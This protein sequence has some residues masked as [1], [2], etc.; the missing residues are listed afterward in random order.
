MAS[1]PA[2]E[3]RGTADDFWIAGPR[4]E[5]DVRR[6]RLSTARRRGGCGCSCRHQSGSVDRPLVP[7]ERH[8]RGAARQ[9]GI[10]VLQTGFAAAE[11]VLEGGALLGQGALRLLFLQARALDERERLFRMLLVG[12]PDDQ[13]GQAL[14]RG[15]HGGPER[16]EVG[17]RR[18]GANVPAR[19]HFIQDQRTAANQGIERRPAGSRIGSR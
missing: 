6:H 3:P 14:L 4:H 15:H 18:V 1:T 10:D 11:V 17:A 12:S 7:G 9:R 8:Q 13:V 2:A 5:R 19:R 16:S